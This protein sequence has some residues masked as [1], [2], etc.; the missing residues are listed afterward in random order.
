MHDIKQIRENPET[1]D[2]GLQARGL[3]PLSAE[4]LELDERHRHIIHR[5]QT[6]QEQKNAV[7]E[8]MGHVKRSGG[9]VTELVA[10]GTRIKEML[11]QVEEEER[12]VKEQ[13]HTLMAVV[14]NTIGIDTPLGTSEEDNELVRTVGKIPQLSFTPK[15][16]FELGEALGMMDFNQ[17][18]QIAG[19]R[20]V[21]L[22]KELDLLERALAT[23][24]IDVHTQEFGYELV[25]PPLLVKSESMYG[26]GQLPKLAEDAFQTTNGH[27]LIPTSEVSLT[28]LA[29]NQILEEKT[30]PL[31]Y[32][33]HTPCF[34]S[35]AGSA[36]RDTRGML[37]QHQFYKVELVS[38]T[39]P[40]Q[41][42]DEFYRMVGA[43]EEILKRLKLPY[44]VMNL[45]SADI[46]FSSKK[47]YDLEVWLPGQNCYREISSCSLCGDF[48]ARRMKARYRKAETK[49]VDFIHTLNGSGIAVGRALIAVLENY[50]TETGSIKI[51]KVLIP[52][53]NGK[54]EVGL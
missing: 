10:E 50:Q 3:A 54:T 16:H 1:F 48:Q 5:L 18:A 22:K 23:F 28:C 7:A 19:S 42:A 47:T 40:E 25:S 43:A 12:L 4:I 41:S 36:G 32:T 15:E 37:R 34:R 53:M 46:G 52:Y 8:Q 38:L 29:A 24:M 26:T 17:A 27:W 6:L 45:C 13:L 2:R 11:P 33:A 44:R 49:K 20:Y 30:L 39:S 35:E 9:D 14:P 51:P 21:I 31:R